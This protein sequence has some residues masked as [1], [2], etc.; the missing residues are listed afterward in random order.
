MTSQTKREN[1]VTEIRKIRKDIKRKHQA[2]TGQASIDQEKLEKQFKPITQ[3][4]NKLINLSVKRGRNDE[5]IEKMPHEIKTEPSMRE[6]VSSSE[7]GESGK[8][9]E[10]YTNKLNNNDPKE[11]DSIYGM[12]YDKNNTLML[13]NS[14]ITFNN[15]DIILNNVKYTGTHG[16][17]ELIF[18][19]KPRDIYTKE[20]LKSYATIL[21]SSN[22]HKCGDKLKANKGYKYT[23]IIKGILPISGSG[24]MS[25]S[26]SKPEYVY[27]NDVNELCDRLR[28]LISSQNAGHSGHE[29]EIIAILEELREA[30]VIN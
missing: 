29:N 24:L 19:K 12:Y 10:L 21:T 6:V 26:K 23:R 30:E 20:D 18:M 3:P 16:L 1:L 25:L 7:V 9:A 5:E 15:D 28:L 8:L 2:L 14:P 13:G 4:L 22:A 27:W 11:I 17:Y